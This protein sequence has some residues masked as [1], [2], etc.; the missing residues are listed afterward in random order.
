ML[1]N[2]VCYYASKQTAMSL[3]KDFEKKKNDT[4]TEPDIG[5]PSIT[6]VLF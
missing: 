5:V 1:G 2:N 3:R 6:S 4:A